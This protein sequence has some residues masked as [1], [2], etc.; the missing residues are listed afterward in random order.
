MMIT[1]EVFHDKDVVVG[2]D[3]D[4]Y[5]EISRFVDL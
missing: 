2:V 5:D 4:D 3:V 1:G